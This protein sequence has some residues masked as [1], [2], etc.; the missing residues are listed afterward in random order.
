M[1]AT[2]AWPPQVNGVVRTLTTTVR[3]LQDWGHTVTV[4]SPADHEQLPVPFYPEIA[5]ALARPHRVTEKLRRARPDHVHIATEGPVG[6][7]VRRACRKLAWQ[8]TTSYHTRFPEY[9]QTLV[10][11]PTRPAYR[12]L[13]HFHSA[14]ARV[15]VATPSLER[16]LVANGF[17]GPFGRWG[18][19]VDPAVFHPAVP[20]DAQLAALPKPLS[21]SVG[22]VSHEKNL[23]AFLDL[24]LPGT[25][26]VVGDG[27]A[28]AELRRRHPA[29]HFLGG[30]KGRALAACYTA[31]D[32]FVFPSRTD[33][34]GLV[35]IEALACGVPVAAYPVMGP[36]DLI[37]APE[38]GALGDDLG[39]AV[40][41]ALTRGDRA[42]C[43]ARGAT[44]T[45]PAAT[46]QFLGNLVPTRN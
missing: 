38:L 27:P 30:R 1:I 41:L 34:F 14:A 28:L 16:D 42:A 13:R 26:A 15:M 29:A 40:R 17:A 44:Y 35:V 45:W 6:W 18:R 12:V 9:L 24:D 33:T 8:F 23:S 36:I 5:L 32:V 3:Q 37:D 10:R 2:D 7:L 46:G 19:G 43:A 25:K 20:P 4:I 21:L 11:L 39:D 31:A 22:R